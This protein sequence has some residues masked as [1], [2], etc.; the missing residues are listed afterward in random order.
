[1]LTTK[2]TET[3]AIIWIPVFSLRA[4][5]AGFEPEDLI[6]SNTERKE[7]RASSLV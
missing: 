7:N 5:E 1:M 3:P 6:P 4:G 2:K